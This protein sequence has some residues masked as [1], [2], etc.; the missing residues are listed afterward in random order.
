MHDAGVIH[1][2][3]LRG[4]TCGRASAAGRAS[5]GV[6]P[7]V[8]ASVPGAGGEERGAPARREP[9]TPYCCAV[10]LTNALYTVNVDRPFRECCIREGNRNQ[11]RQTSRP[12]RKGTVPTAIWR[13]LVKEKNEHFHCYDD[14]KISVFVRKRFCIIVSTL[15]QLFHEYWDSVRSYLYKRQVRMT[16]R[17]SRRTKCD[18][19]DIVKNRSNS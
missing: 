18:N 14:V 15:G 3:Q 16:N 17:S 5:G 7:S 11:Q 9:I 4:Q 2:N 13:S 8:A 10:R 1:T 6:G 12:T 19:S